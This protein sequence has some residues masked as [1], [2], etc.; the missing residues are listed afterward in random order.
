[1]TLSRWRAVLGYGGLVPF[2][3]LSALVW[4]APLPVARY[5]VTAQLAYGAVILGFVGAVHWGRS[6]AVEPGGGVAALV[7]SVLP[8]LWAWVALMVDA[9]TGLFMLIGGL[10][11]AWALDRWVLYAPE[12]GSAWHADFL[13]LR[14][15]LSAVAV[16]CLLA[17][18]AAPAS[19]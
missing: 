4:V 11:L 18:L 13:R 14:G 17:T 10:V 7:W 16:L 5:L 15:R 1:M 19:A 3:T 12:R 9:P 2:V 8:S 6:L